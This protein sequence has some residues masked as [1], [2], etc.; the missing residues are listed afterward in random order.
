MKAYAYL[1]FNTGTGAVYINGKQIP[2]G[3]SYQLACPTPGGRIDF[4]RLRITF[5]DNTDGAVE[6][7]TYLAENFSYQEV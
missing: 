5:E 6:V 1:F 7:S 2:E 3:Q 4:K